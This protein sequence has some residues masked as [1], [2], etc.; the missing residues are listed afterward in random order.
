MYVP[1]EMIWV[2]PPPPPPTS[3]C[4][5]AFQPLLRPLAPCGTVPTADPLWR[6]TGSDVPYSDTADT[7]HRPAAGTA[8]RQRTPSGRTHTLEEHRGELTADAST[9]ERIDAGKGRGQITTKGANPDGEQHDSWVLLSLY[10][11]RFVF[12]FTFYSLFLDTSLCIFVFSLAV[13]MKPL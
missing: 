2:P 5:D 8:D 10:F 3:L 7:A 13:A 4:L 9:P 6:Q 12:H 1:S 11:L